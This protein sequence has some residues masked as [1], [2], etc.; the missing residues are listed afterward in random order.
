[1]S[2]PFSEFQP[3]I[4]NP[5]TLNSDIINSMDMSKITSGYY[6][7]RDDLTSIFPLADYCE[8]PEEGK[9]AHGYAVTDATKCRVFSRGINKNFL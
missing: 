8:V 7:I 3:C 6:S 5:S 9:C 4:T 1:M 2:N